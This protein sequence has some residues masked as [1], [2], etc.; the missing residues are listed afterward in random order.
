[1]NDLALLS[2]KCGLA[3]GRP[4][5]DNYKTVFSEAKAPG[6]VGSQLRVRRRFPDPGRL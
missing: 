1:M 5:S 6:S 4:E 2:I 3:V